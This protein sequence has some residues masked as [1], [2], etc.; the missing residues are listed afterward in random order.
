MT[1]QPRIVFCGNIADNPP[2]GKEQGKKLWGQYFK[3]IL[4]STTQSLPIEVAVAVQAPTPP[5]RF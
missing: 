5:P 4:N 2:G 1:I 3:G